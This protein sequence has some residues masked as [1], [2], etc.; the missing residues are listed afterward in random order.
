M[1]HPA[2]QQCISFAAGSYNPPYFKRRIIRSGLRLAV[3]KKGRFEMW[4]FNDT[5]RPLYQKMALGAD[6]TAQV[7]RFIGFPHKIIGSLFTYKYRRCLYKLTS[8]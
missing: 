4:R 2:S 8:L 6:Q 1:C 7:F 3:I 5:S